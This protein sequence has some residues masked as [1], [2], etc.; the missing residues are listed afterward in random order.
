MDKKIQKINSEHKNEIEEMKQKFQK[1]MEE[2]NERLSAEN[3]VCLQKKDEKIN[4]LE[5]EIKKVLK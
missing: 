4:F 1:L 3:D 2:N 5:E